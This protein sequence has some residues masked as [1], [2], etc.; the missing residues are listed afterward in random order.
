ML[1]DSINTRIFALQ[2]VPPPCDVLRTLPRPLE[3]RTPPV[4]SAHILSYLPSSCKR[5]PPDRACPPRIAS[6]A[7]PTRKATRDAR[8]IRDSARVATCRTA[9]CLKKGQRVEQSRF[10]VSYF[11]LFLVYALSGPLRMKL[12]SWHVL[13]LR[14][15]T[16]SESLCSTSD[17]WVRRGLAEW[18][19][20]LIFSSQFPRSRCSLR[21]ACRWLGRRE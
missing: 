5:Y 13:R 16:A 10:K 1:P 3:S 14:L 11:S 12:K 9:R 6:D 20:Y 19:L 2:Q 15:C 18:L 4:G 7:L 21:S 8:E 17:N